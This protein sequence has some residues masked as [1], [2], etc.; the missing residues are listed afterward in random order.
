[1]REFANAHVVTVAD[2]FS[3]W[4]QLV[5]SLT[6]IRSVFAENKP[7][8]DGLKQFTLQLVSSATEK[9]GWE[10]RPEEDYLTGQL[11]ALLI[12]TAGGAGH[13]TYNPI[14]H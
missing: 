14:C 6:N 1:M 7:V 8:A 2:G 10:F 4:A 3:I 11:R 13:T 9:V 5:S 12:S